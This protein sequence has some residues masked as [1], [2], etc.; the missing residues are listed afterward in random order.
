MVS[1]GVA[2]VAKLQLPN[3]PMGVASIIIGGTKV[4][5]GVPKVTKGVAR[6]AKGR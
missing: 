1:K 5:R 6:V 3:T 4:T 2:D